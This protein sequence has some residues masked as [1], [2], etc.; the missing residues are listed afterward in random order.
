MRRSLI[1]M[2]L[3]VTA[4]L[5]AIPAAAQEPFIGE[6]DLVAFDFAPKGYAVCQGQILSIQQN[7]ALFALLG[8]TYG[9][10]GV[11]T[12]ALPDLRGRRII[13]SGQGPGLSPYSL[14][15]VGGE[16]TVTLTVPQMP[17]HTH[18][19]LASS[20]PAAVLSPSGSFWGSVSG[21][22]LFSTAPTPAAMAPA[23]IGSTGGGQPHDNMQ[24]YLVMNYIIALNGIF[25][26]R[27]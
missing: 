11:Q 2:L 13:S 8:T 22:S 21:T 4:L 20:A 16:E 5:M 23:A 17:A 1:T 7:Q 25:P 6:I 26:S 9:G 24:P 14:G 12:F 15:Q 19:P 18:L 3:G 27:D 10:N